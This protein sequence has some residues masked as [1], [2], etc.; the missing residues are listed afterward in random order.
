MMVE[1]YYEQAGKGAG[2]TQSPELNRQTL[3]D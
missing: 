3:N 1:K 2:G